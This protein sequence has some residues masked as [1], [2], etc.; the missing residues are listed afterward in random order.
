MVKRQRCSRFMI[1]LWASLL[2]TTGGTATA[3]D[4]TEPRMRQDITFLAS[5]QCEGRGVATRALRLVADWALDPAGLGLL[6][7][8]MQIFTDNERSCRV[9]E[10]AHSR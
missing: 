2:L 3:Q 5:D 4:P 6:R 1:P 10:R 8:E 7:L 9:A